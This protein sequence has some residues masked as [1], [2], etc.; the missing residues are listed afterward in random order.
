MNI[1]KIL[2]LVGKI[3]LIIFIVASGLGSLATAY[4]IFAPDTL[5]KPFY[6]Q[7]GYGTPTDAAAPGAQANPADA[8]KTE[9]AAPVEVHPGQG[10]MFNTGTKIIN[11]AESTGRKYIRITVVL[12]YVPPDSTYSEMT[13]EEKTAYV[14]SFT[15]EITAKQPLIDDTII[16]LLSAKSFD[17]LYTADGKEALRAELLEKINQSMPEYKVISV[18]FTEFVVE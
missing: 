12:E 8:A 11:L 18:Y 1:M 3:F 6:L 10:I 9:P 7:Y 4:I 14:T 13:A 5:P 2:G 17:Q 15:S 16:T